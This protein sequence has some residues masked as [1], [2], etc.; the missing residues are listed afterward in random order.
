[1]PISLRKNKINFI[2]KVKWSNRVNYNHIFDRYD[3]TLTHNEWLV[4]KFRVQ[5]CAKAKIQCNEWKRWMRTLTA[6]ER[7][8]EKEKLNLM[9]IK[10]NPWSEGNY[11]LRMKKNE[12]NKQNSPCSKIRH[13]FGCHR[14]SAKNR[15][16]FAN[17]DLRLCVVCYSALCIGGF[18]M[19][20]RY[21][22]RVTAL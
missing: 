19:V 12:S 7:E 6:K 22:T 21:C 11:W 10:A 14:S 2:G 17:I 13:H 18:C 4:A 3:H 1:M 5:I 9:R 15:V 8:R 20:L 16:K